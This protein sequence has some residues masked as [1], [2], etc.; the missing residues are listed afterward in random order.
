MEIDICRLPVV[1]SWYVEI[2]HTLFIFIY[3]VLIYVLSRILSPMM[4]L[5]ISMLSIWEYGNDYCI[6][7][8]MSTDGYY[9]DLCLVDIWLTWVRF[10]IEYDWLTNSVKYVHLLSMIYQVLSHALRQVDTY[11]GYPGYSSCKYDT[12]VGH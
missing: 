9:S 7:E 8:C 2:E 6:S 4:S 10:P 5:V 3:W 11:S 12:L 1:S